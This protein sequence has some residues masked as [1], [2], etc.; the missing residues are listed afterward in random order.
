MQH[1][2][3]PFCCVFSEAVSI[4]GYIASMVGCRSFGKDVEGTRRSLTEVISQHLPEWTEEK[5]KNLV[6]VTSMSAGFESGICWIQ[7]YN[8]TIK[9]NCLVITNLH[10]TLVVKRR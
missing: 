7:I 4:L 5:D 6:R 10:V 1:N 3:S 8:V 9:P 2:K